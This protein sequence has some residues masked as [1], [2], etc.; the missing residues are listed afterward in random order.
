METPHIHYRLA[1]KT[2]LEQISELC[3]KYSLPLPMLETCFVAVAGDQVVGFVN[4]TIEPIVETLISDNPV[5]AR[6][7]MDMVTGV[8]LAMGKTRMYCNTDREDV[9]AVAQ[10][11]GFKKTN[12]VSMLK[13]FL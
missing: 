13:E 5:S 4:L 3:R 8:V 6:V 7:L 10:K 2:D 12:T 11:Y 9:I 1:Q